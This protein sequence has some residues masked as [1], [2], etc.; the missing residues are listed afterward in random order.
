MGGEFPI[1]ETAE[2]T[3]APLFGVGGDVVSMRRHRRKRSNNVTIIA[4]VVLVAVA[5]VLVAVLI[6]VLS[7]QGAA[8]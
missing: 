5:I 3:S 1:V 7:R 4:S 2:A 6:Y 8:T